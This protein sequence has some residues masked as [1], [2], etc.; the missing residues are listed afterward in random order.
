MTLKGLESFF[1]TDLFF[2]RSIGLHQEAEYIEQ[3][4]KMKQ[5]TG[6]PVSIPV[7]MCINPATCF[8]FYEVS[9]IIVV[10]TANGNAQ[11]MAV[12]AAAAQQQAQSSGQT[13]YSK[14]WAEYYR[15]IGKNDEAEAIENQI[16][17]IK[18]SNHDLRK[19]QTISISFHLSFQKGIFIKPESK[20]KSSR[21]ERWLWIRTTRNGWKLQCSIRSVLRWRSCWPK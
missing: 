15:S 6:Q 19:F 7:G 2:C 8:F 14:Q 9:L 20:C 17:V 5:A 12:A 13:D 11:S 10:F 16:K 18:V 3:Q 21:S 4:L 1:L